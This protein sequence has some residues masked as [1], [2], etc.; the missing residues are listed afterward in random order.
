MTVRT[1]LRALG[2]LFYAIAGED[3]RAL[4]SEGDATDL[5]ARLRSVGLRDFTVEGTYA[6][7]LIVRAKPIS[8]IS[9]TPRPNGVTPIGE[10]GGFTL[11]DDDR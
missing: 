10:G 11:D 7:G 2:V 4:V 1:A 3:G 5:A 8:G 6:G 9:P